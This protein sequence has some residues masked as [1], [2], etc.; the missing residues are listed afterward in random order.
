MAI[1]RINEF[2]AL[3]GRAEELHGLL[4]RALPA[5]ESSAGC[6]SARLLRSADDAARF[7]VIE[8]W[9]SVAA[10]RDSLRSIP[11]EALADALQ[12]LSEPP[13]GRYF[14]D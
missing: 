9:D 13:A 2:R 11:P 10:H 4:A 3:D 7:V 12:L 6:R 14:R 8:E 5:I 1:V